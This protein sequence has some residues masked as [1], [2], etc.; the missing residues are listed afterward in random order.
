MASSL[1]RF[2]R[3]RI[4]KV[5][6]D[7]Y[8]EDVVFAICSSE[9]QIT[10]WYKINADAHIYRE[11]KSGIVGWDKEKTN[12]SGQVYYEAVPM[13]VVLEFKKNLPQPWALG[14][15]AHEI[16]HVSQHICKRVGIK[17]KGR[18][19]REAQAYLVEFLMRR[20]ME[21]CS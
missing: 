9:T 10:E 16:C 6:V 4:F 13:L 7:L 1:P 3:H 20:F 15:I 12:T 8:K 17:G 5:P 21:E 2:M 18:A 19:A 14:V 11:C